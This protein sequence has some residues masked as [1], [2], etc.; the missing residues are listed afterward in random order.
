MSSDRT[1]E[2]S[3]RPDGLD[4]TRLAW[5]FVIS[6]L[7][8]ALCYG[9]YEVG[10]KFDLWQN[11]HLPKW[12]QKHKTAKQI[13]AEEKQ[14]AMQ[15]QEIPLVF[16]ETTPA[17][18]VPDEPKDA[19][20]YSDKNTKAANRNAD[21]DSN[22]PKIEGSQT[23][24]PKT[25]NVPREIYS[26]LQPSAQPAPPQEEQ[27]PKPA[28]P[29][30]DLAMVKPEQLKRQTQGRD[31][32]ERP[33][34]LQEAKA[35]QQNNKIPIPMMK[36]EGGV[37]RRLDFSSLDA[38]ATPFGAYDA[39]FIG[40]VSDRWFGLLENRAYASDASGRVVLQFHLLYNGTIT[41]MRVVENTAGEM[42]GLIC[43]KAVLDPA[44]F[45]A[46]PTEMRRAVGESRSIQFTF[47]Y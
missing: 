43:Q 2:I 33:R 19:K 12:L 7:I 45:A 21:A 47:Y 26:P 22:T 35:R 11:L 46:W 41:D 44:P 5:A 29:P 37:K 15:Q 30:G 8:H 4:S 36:Q 27:K 9:T 3:L 18:V 24:V 38:K 1:K 28:M 10:K 25:E 17:Q 39:A 34:T 31:E 14:L 32:Q 42:L 20:Y 13:L 40:A 6:I 23:H 16:V